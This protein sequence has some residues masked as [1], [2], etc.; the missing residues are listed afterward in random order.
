MTWCLFQISTYKTRSWTVF[1]WIYVIAGALLA[2]PLAIGQIL[3]ETY[4]R[5][6]VSWLDP[7]AL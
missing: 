4:R 1:L 5:A 7:A 6:R 2:V 3:W